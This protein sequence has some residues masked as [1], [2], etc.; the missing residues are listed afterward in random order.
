VT[1]LRTAGQG[2]R[3]ADIAKWLKDIAFFKRIRNFRILDPLK[4]LLQEDNLTAAAKRI[5]KYWGS[6]P[7]HMSREGY[8]LLASAAAKL[9]TE[10]WGGQDSGEQHASTTGSGLV[11]AHINLP[12][13][14]TRGRRPSWIVA[15]DAVAIRNMPTRVRARGGGKFS[16]RWNFQKFGSGRGGS[17]WRARGGNRGGRM[18]RGGRYRPY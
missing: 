1:N 16:N 15:D 17:Q 3:L 4:H 11:G 8:Q 18:G 2:E 5:S 9:A 13:Q 10:D 14:N 7:V 12:Q 6:D